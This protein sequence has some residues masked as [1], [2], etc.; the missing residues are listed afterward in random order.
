MNLFFSLRERWRLLPRTV[1]EVF[2][3]F[4]AMGVLYRGR[5][6]YK[7]QTSL[8]SPF[9][10]DAKGF[11]LLYLF[12]HVWQD[13]AVALTVA[14]GFWFMVWMRQ[15]W[16]PDHHWPRFLRLLLVPVL[17][18]V[19]GMG[20]G[21]HFQLVFMMNSGLVFDLVMEGFSE[22]ATK[23]GFF[24]YV[25]L[26]DL[27]I[28]VFPVLLFAVL[29][30]LTGR[31]R[32]WMDRMLILFVFAAGSMVVGGI[33]LR[34]PG[35]P[36]ELRAN[37]TVYLVSDILSRLRAREAGPDLSRHGDQMRSVALV[38]PVFVQGGEPAQARIWA[39]ER[40]W[41]V[42]FIVMESTGFR[43]IFDTGHKNEVPMP[44]LKN[45][46]EKGWFFT[47]H[48]SSSNSSAR[49]LFSIFSGLYIK[50]QIEFFETGKNV[51]L[52]SYFSF[53]PKRKT[54][55]VTPG[56]LH[57]YF[58]HA[59]LAH[60]GL[61]EMHGFDE[62]ED[63]PRKNEL[64][65]IVFARDERET[66]GFFLD[67]LDE[68]LRRGDGPFHV[69]Y[70][71]MVP[72]WPY[73]SYGPDFNIFPWDASSLKLKYYN[74][75]RLLDTQIKRIY[76]FVEKKGLLEDTIFVI[77]GDHGEAFGQHPG[78]YIHSRA[79]YQENVHTP[80][81]LYQPEIFEPRRIERY[82]SHVDILPTLLDGMKIEY[83]PALFQG[84]SLFQKELRRKYIFF[85]G[86]ENTMSS[87]AVDTGVKVQIDLA[88]RSC[89]AWNLREDP[90][91]KDSGS[92]DE[93]ADQKEALQF[94][95]EYTLQILDSYN[96]QLRTTGGFF[97][98]RHPT[99]Q[100]AAYAEEE[101]A[102]EER[103]Q[104]K[105]REAEAEEAASESKRRA[106]VEKEKKASAEKEKAGREKK[107]KAKKAN[108]DWESSVEYLE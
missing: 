15:R 89:H 70:Y 4:F 82:T 37:P 33:F 23:A 54:L 19:I 3:I 77:T 31:L 99:R 26:P 101:F 98:E 106:A 73:T 17:A 1:V 61:R 104:Q 107:E 96:D 97:G 87:I 90:D 100:L 71:S 8:H 43:Y 18:L 57:W 30:A 55:L 46:S 86:N 93:H 13:I 58:P 34:R 24:S 49:S 102:V 21:S 53:V 25:T 6:Y 2:F 91:E 40:Q 38:D 59:F 14:A 5:L 69:V 56:P 22:Q 41:N 11:P 80:L 78:N 35:L 65:N 94:F 42:V 7:V 12:H 62:L 88:V 108:R 67:R 39:E 44:F 68:K 81:L 36:E 74:N 95:K 79:S 92:C 27:I 48:H 9:A 75:L 29:T 76:E 45:L 10:L 52:P 103:A 16:L 85:Y 32:K 63:I 60:S 50:P 47:N 20:Y 28:W 64:E 51:V 105:D 66:A 83:N 84:E 72:H